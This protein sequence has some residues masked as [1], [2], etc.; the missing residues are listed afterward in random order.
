MSGS[1]NS[2]VTDQQFRIDFPAF[3]DPEVYPRGTVN[4]WLKLANN[5]LDPN[6]WQDFY[7]IGQEL[8]AAHWITMSKQDEERIR[9]GQNT[10]AGPVSSKSA[11]GVSMSFSEAAM[12]TGAGHWNLTTFGRQF[13]RIARM[14]GMGGIQLN[15][16][17]P[18]PAGLF[19][20]NY[21]PGSAEAYDGAALE[22]ETPTG[23]PFTQYS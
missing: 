12:E 18:F 5:L 17:T 7:I 4:M 14:G 1:T 3:K 22:Q 8:F 16:C 10:N 23:S 13:I 21:F 11:G 20:G 9:R 2:P 15:G 19:P 6:I